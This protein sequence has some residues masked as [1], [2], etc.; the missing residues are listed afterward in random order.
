MPQ[1]TSNPPRVC[2]DCDGFAAAIIT[3]GTRST[4]GTRTTIRVNCPACRGLGRTVP[5]AFVRVGR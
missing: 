5:A 1:T 4:D 3:T 2:R